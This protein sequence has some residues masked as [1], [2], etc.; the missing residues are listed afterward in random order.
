MLEAQVFF[1]PNPVELY[2]QLC[3]ESRVLV[4]QLRMMM[5]EA[6][7]LNPFARQVWK[8]LETDFPSWKQHLDARCGELEFA[9][10]A[11]SGSSAG[12][13]VVFTNNND[14]WLRFAPPHMCYLVDDENEMVSL[15]RQLTADELLF[16]VTVNGDQWVETTLAAP[17]EKPEPFP[18][19][20]S[21]FVSW[22]GRCDR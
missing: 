1:D 8:R 2:R 12:H 14:I 22:S 18:G 21:R 10:P 16:K 17:G 11:P 15:I 20:S 13:L 4:G 7:V 6:Q 9:V 19:Y 3:G 5:E